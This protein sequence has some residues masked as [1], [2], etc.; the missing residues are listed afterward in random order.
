MITTFKDE[1]TNNQGSMRNE[2]KRINIRRVKTVWRLNL[3]N[4]PSYVPYKGS[5]VPYEGTFG[6]P[7]Q[8]Q[9][10]DMWESQITGSALKWLA[11]YRSTSYSWNCS[12]SYSWRYSWTH[13]L[14]T[15]TMTSLILDHVA[16]DYLY[17]GT[18]MEIKICSWNCPRTRLW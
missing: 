8:G 15:K 17:L 1:W 4:E 13:V 11:P 9:T 3:K 10:L 7:N 5:Y 6:V 16:M 18:G 14:G 12:W 2:L